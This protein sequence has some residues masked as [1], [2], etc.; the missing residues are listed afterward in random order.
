MKYKITDGENTEFKPIT[1]TITI[2]SLAEL[3]NFWHR[4]NFDEY[5]LKQFADD[6]EEH[7]GI[8]GEFKDPNGLHGFWDDI[9][10]LLEQRR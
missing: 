7:L 9:D 3:A 8:D 2:E 1:V 10:S 5:E 6:Y 4:L